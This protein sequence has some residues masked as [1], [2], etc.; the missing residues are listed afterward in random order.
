MNSKFVVTCIAAAIVGVLAYFAAV[1]VTF[2]PGVAALYPAA[3]FEAAFGAWF[4]VYGAIA[5]Y[6]GLLFAGATGGWFSL[7]AGLLLSLSDL[8]LAIAPAVAVRRGIF[9]PALPTA[10]DAA[11]FW[12]VSLFLGSLPGSLLYNFVNL[13]LEALAGWNSF[14]VAVI[15]WNVGNA[16][17]LAVLGIPLMR[18]GTTL[19][20][21][22]GLF[23]QRLF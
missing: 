14:W 3:A 9:D 21:Q 1:S 7:Q 20:K 13:K 19:I 10:S 18:I 6:V 17:V 11:K 2:I 8:I 15:G 12:A 23:V 16:I 4:G 22:R 5:S